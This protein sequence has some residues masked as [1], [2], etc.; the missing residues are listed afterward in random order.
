MTIEQ[1]GQSVQNRYPQYQGMDPAT[2]GQKMLQQ[3]PQYQSQINQ[4][5][6][7]GNFLGNLLSGIAKPFVD[8]GK[9]IGAAVYEGGR[10]LDSAAGSPVAHAMGSMNDYQDKTGNT[11]ND[12]FLSQQ[13]TENYHTN[14]LG[15][16]L[17]QAKDSANIASYA[18]PFGKGANMLTKTLLPGAVSGG[19]QGVSQQNVTPSSLAGSIGMGAAGAGVMGGLAKILGIAPA[20]TQGASES[21]NNAG[22]AITRSQY[23]LPQRLSSELDFPQAVSTVANTT[24]I[25]NRREA[26][27]LAGNMINAFS[28]VVSKATNNS[29]PVDL[30]GMQ[31]FTKDSLAKATELQPH[32]KDN[33]QALLNNDLVYP[34]DGT[35]DIVNANPTKVMQV[36][37]N[38]EAT[39]ADHAEAFSRN[40]NVVD[41][42]AATLYGNV[43]DELR[44]RLF[45]GYENPNTGKTTTGANDVLHQMLQDPKISEQIHAINPQLGFQFDQEAPKGVQ[46]VRHM[47]APYVAISKANQYATNKSVNNVISPL[48]F[49][50]AMSQLGS[51]PLGALSALAAEKTV[52]SNASKGLL[53][54]MLMKAGQRIPQVAAPS[55]G[56]QGAMKNVGAHIGPTIQQAT[57]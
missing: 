7:Q 3:Y 47:M 32:Q 42:Q 8:T 49:F 55:A 53:G 15:Q 43:A 51:N 5:G 12:P 35:R 31:N 11:I 9:N 19:L 21:L 30:G 50:G 10:A 2:V 41:K 28:D 1:F 36:I 57:Q 13:D 34:S 27:D 14:P 40:G 54:G 20:V 33:I 26:S 17:N 56:L 23:M 39:G 22:N 29:N 4:Q 45:N 6:P 18:V 38:L 25:T 52:N 44:N 46:A 48:E 16:I 24:G 37:R